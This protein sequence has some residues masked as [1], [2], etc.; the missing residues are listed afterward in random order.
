MCIYFHSY[1]FVHS[2]TAGIATLKIYVICFSSILYIS[3]FS[4]LVKP[5]SML[6]KIGQSLTIFLVKY[7]I[8]N[9]IWRCTRSFTL[10]L[11]HCNLN[12]I[13]CIDL[14]IDFFVLLLHW[15][16]LIITVFHH[17]AAILH[18]HWSLHAVYIL[19]ITVMLLFYSCIKI[20]QRFCCA[21]RDRNIM[22]QW[23]C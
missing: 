23:A 14:T 10:L 8:E 16:H 21:K 13:S 15:N 19:R 11:F 4:N 3:F 6:K 5:F 17:T 12:E 20:S 18:M 2:N 9:N 22:D 1:E 7:C